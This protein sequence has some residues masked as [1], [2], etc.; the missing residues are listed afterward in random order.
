MDAIS[1]SG[2]ADVYGTQ[3]SWSEIVTFI[4]R[5]FTTFLSSSSELFLSLS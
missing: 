5:V 2:T 4:M 1:E 3:V